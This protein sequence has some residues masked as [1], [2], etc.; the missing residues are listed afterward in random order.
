MGQVPLQDEKGGIIF[1]LLPSLYSY[2][3]VLV[4]SYFR[5]TVKLNDSNSFVST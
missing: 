4:S 2:T 5:E 1:F 3:L